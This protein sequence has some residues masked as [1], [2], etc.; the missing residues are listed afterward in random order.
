MLSDG[1]TKVAGTRTTPVLFWGKMYDFITPVLPLV[2]TRVGRNRVGRGIAMISGI[3]PIN[4]A[5]RS[6]KT[7]LSATRLLVDRLS[8]P[9]VEL[10]A[11]QFLSQLEICNFNS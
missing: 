10:V 3:V 1:N 4:T 8:A 9:F 7:R 11:T 5:R 6:G 2:A